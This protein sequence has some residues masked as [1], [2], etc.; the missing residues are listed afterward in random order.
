MSS[1][2]STDSSSDTPLDRLTEEPPGEKG[3][4]LC[5]YSDFSEKCIPLQRTYWEEV[6]GS[7]EGIG[8]YLENSVSIETLLEQGLT[9]E[10]ADC[11]DKEKA[12]RLGVNNGRLR[13]EDGEISLQSGFEDELR[14]LKRLQ[15]EKRMF[16]DCNERSFWEDIFEE[17]G[18]DTDEQIPRKALPVLANHVVEFTEREKENTDSE[19]K[20]HI[21]WAQ[22]A[23]YTGIELKPLVV[24]D[25]PDSDSEYE[26]VKL[27]EPDG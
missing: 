13:F 1:K 3:V 27:R 14:I 21:A 25:E 6:F 19:K 8:P 10:F 17:Y 16:T 24:V 12:I 5:K 4:T 2:E 20:D 26:M 22:G 7:I 9:S 11:D 18:I 15:K 23:V